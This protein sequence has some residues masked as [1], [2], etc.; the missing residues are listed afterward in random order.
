[1]HLKQS[2]PAASSQP[3]SPRKRV[4]LDEA[5]ASAGEQFRGGN[6]T[7]LTVKTT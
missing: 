3:L 7:P 5:E 6:S 4:L 1:M 2:D